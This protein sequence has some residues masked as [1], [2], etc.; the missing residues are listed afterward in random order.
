MNSRSSWSVRVR[1]SRLAKRRRRWRYV[2][3]RRR[4]RR[5]DASAE[6]R[7]TLNHTPL[8]SPSTASSLNL[9]IESRVP[10]RG[11]DQTEPRPFWRGR[12]TTGLSTGTPTRTRGCYHRR[13]GNRGLRRIVQA[14]GATDR[15]CAELRFLSVPLTAHPKLHRAIR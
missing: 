3:N 9:L 15:Y 10:L 6:E 13:R 14:R 5:K 4:R 11:V 8:H 7:H 1:S 12:I 2:A